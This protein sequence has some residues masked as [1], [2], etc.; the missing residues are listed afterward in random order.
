MIT[1]IT[2][3][4]ALG[5]KDMQKSY[6][7]VQLV[8]DEAYKSISKDAKAWTG[9]FFIDKEVLKLPGIQNFDHYKVDK[10]HTLY[11]DFL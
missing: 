5:V 7:T 8:A 1:T 11:Q 3:E 2:V 10:N 4:C 6:R 9:N